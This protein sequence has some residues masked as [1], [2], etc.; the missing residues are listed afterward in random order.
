MS[1]NLVRSLTFQQDTRL[2]YSGEEK[3][4]MIVINRNLSLIAQIDL[5]ADWI[6]VL[7]ANSLWEDT[8]LVI[9]KESED[10]STKY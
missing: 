8:Y 3:N 1:V 6:P 7:R 9:S 5:S 2:I 10:F 4:N